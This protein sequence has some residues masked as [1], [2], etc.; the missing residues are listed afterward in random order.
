LKR[1]RILSLACSF[2]NFGDGY[3]WQ[4]EAWIVLL[5]GAVEVNGLAQGVLR[6]VAQWPWIEHSTFK[7]T[8]GHFTELLPPLT[9]AL[10]GIPLFTDVYLQSIDFHRN[11]VTG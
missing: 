11:P 10:F 7:L 9:L 4:A 3:Q 6:Q 2:V 8:S 5:A 1:W